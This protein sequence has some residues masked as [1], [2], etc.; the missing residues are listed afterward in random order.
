MWDK[1]LWGIEFSDGLAFNGLLGSTWNNVKE[2]K[3]YDGEPTHCLL[4]ETKNAARLWCKAKM[5][6]YADRSDDTAALRFR[7]VLVKE[8]VKLI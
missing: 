8:T 3:R 5:S 2:E 4:F 1:N 6:G 7:A